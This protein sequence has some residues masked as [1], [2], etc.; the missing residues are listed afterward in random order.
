MTPS[1]VGVLAYQVWLYVLKSCQYLELSSSKL[2]SI[3]L[4]NRSRTGMATLTLIP[5]NALEE[6]L[7]YLPL[8]LDLGVWRF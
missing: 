1:G 6:V 3:G 7:L 8:A 4:G 2:E 5:N